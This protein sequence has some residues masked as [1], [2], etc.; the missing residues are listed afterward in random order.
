MKRVGND[1]AVGEVKY[2]SKVSVNFGEESGPC[3][4]RGAVELG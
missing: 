1:G 3:W 4:R 2:R